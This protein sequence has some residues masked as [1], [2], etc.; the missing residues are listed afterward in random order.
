[1]IA[2]WWAIW[3][4]TPGARFASVF[5][6]HYPSWLL[7]WVAPLTSI[8]LG[9]VVACLT[10]RTVLEQKWTLSDISRLAWWSA[11][12][13]TVALLFVATGFETI[14]EGRIGG[15]FV[16]LMAGVAALVGSILLRRAEGLQLRRVKS[17]ELY[18]RA[19]QLA[20]RMKVKL[21]SVYVVPPGRG[22]LTNAYATRHSIAVT[23][24]YGKFLN[25]SQLEFVISHEL[26]HL[27]QKHRRKDFV[28]VAVIFLVMTVMFFK[29]SPLALRYRPLINMTVTF[30][31]LLTY[32]YFSRQS[33]YAADQTAVEFTDDAL[34]GV[35]ALANLYK[36][37]NPPAQCSSFIELFLTHPPLV[38]RT[39]A[40]AQFK[41]IPIQLVKDILE[42]S[43]LIEV[44]LPKTTAEIAN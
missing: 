6:N 24:N 2:F 16:L 11:F 26:A 8:G 25:R 17:G 32:Y 15:I 1:M 12:S 10:S 38:R 42:Q 27:K 43:G 13:P 31:P 30:I 21:I 33:E 4:S 44:E 35:K 40:I 22:E 34:S 36:F 28:F 7:F 41:Q 20:K 39:M 37:T 19:F 18:N 29:L 14:Y 23:D 9:Q 3:D 5:F